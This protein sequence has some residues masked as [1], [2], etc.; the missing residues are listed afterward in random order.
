MTPSA[1]RCPW[2]KVFSVQW[3][4]S[5]GVWPPLPRAPSPPGSRAPATLGSYGP[6][7]G[8]HSLCPWHLLCLRCSPS[9]VLTLRPVMELPAASSHPGSLTQP[10][11]S[12]V[13]AP[14]TLE[15]HPSVLSAIWT[16]QSEGY[17][18]VPAPWNCRP[19][20]PARDLA[21]AQGVFAECMR[22]GYLDPPTSPQTCDPISVVL[23]PSPASSLWQTPPPPPLTSACG[24]CAAGGGCA[25]PPS[26]TCPPRACSCRR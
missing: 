20:P 5:P 22:G 16:L 8:P 9:K 1:F 18:S 11:G 10:L 23:C 4:M 15:L 12:S 21:D 26:R 19:Q 3:S 17:L 25:G 24:P 6:L 2:E 13:T 14:F 7:Q